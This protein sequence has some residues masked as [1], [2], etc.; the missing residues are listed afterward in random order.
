[1]KMKLIARSL[2]AMC[3]IG[4]QSCAF[5]QSGRID[6]DPGNENFTERGL[7]RGIKATKAACS[8]VQGAVWAALSAAEGE[9]V[10]Y[11]VAGLTET[12]SSSV[13][14]YFSGDLLARDRLL[15]TD[16]V[17]LNPQK[18]Q[19]TVVARQALL[20]VP[21]IVVGRPGMYGSSGEHKQRRR[22]EEG[23]LVSSAIDEIK[24]V[25]KLTDISVVGQSGGGHVVASLLTYRSDI[26][27]AVPASSVSSPRMRWQLR[28]QAMDF[29]G[30][31]DSYEPVDNLAQGRFNPKLRVFV[32]GDPQ[33]S[34][35]P[36]NT[37]LPLAVRLRELGVQVEVL[38]GQGSGRERHGLNAS[39]LMIGSL[40]SQ[41]H[42]TPEI[43]IKTKEGLK[44]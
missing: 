1:M 14:F 9:C 10:R 2:L 27:C 31:V 38:E 29:T 23:R 43:L 42:T 44:G 34:N 35:V 36:W 5:A 16:Y 37:Q 26:V 30:F 4:M 12:N 25:H 40:C 15:E 32:L 6:F 11:W 22:A 20:G 18:M 19:S 24:K 7:V 3:A 28:G 21:Y 17:W 13:L 39:A 8:Q 41:G 33:D